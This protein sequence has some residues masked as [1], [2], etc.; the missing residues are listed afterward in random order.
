MPRRFEQIALQ[1]PVCLL[2]FSHEL[3]LANC[4]YMFYNLSVRFRTYIRE[5]GGPVLG[6]QKQYAC[7]DLKSFY[8]SVECVDRGLDLSPPTWWWP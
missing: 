2:T 6:L 1:A 7:I 5:G 8:A 3:G 4:E